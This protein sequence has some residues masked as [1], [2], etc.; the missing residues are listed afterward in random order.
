MGLWKK[1]AGVG[2][3]ERKRG[4]AIRGEERRERGFN[5]ISSF[6]LIYSGRMSQMEEDRA[7]KSQDGTFHSINSRLDFSE[8][9]YLYSFW[10]QFGLCYGHSLFW[11]WQSQESK[12]RILS[13]HLPLPMRR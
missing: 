13:T 3:G 4:E 7:Q 2:D 9:S 5:P 1:G 6:T 10:V 8:K 11:T 12:P